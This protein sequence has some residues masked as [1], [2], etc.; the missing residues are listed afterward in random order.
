MN[1]TNQS[2]IRIGD[3]LLGDGQ[4]CFVIAEVGNI[5]NGVYDLVIALVVSAVASGADCAKF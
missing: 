3:R 1:S 2:S 4:P 5:H